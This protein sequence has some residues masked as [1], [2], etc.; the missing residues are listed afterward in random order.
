MNSKFRPS[1]GFV[2]ARPSSYVSSVFAL[3]ALMWSWPSHLILCFSLAFALV[4]RTEANWSLQLYL[5][6][7]KPEGCSII[8][9]FLFVLLLE[10][11]EI[12]ENFPPGK[13]PAYRLRADDI[14]QSASKALTQFVG[15]AVPWDS[16]GSC[17]LRSEHLCRHS[18]WVTI[19]GAVIYSSGL[20]TG[21]GSREMRLTK[22]SM[23]PF[24]LQV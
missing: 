5:F 9:I 8:I 16:H 12:R 2:Q 17:L 21:R 15:T 1:W 14:N 4:V 6:I 13:N 19:W 11:I 23:W 10:A 7:A 22:G 18:M 24:S 3:L 20:S